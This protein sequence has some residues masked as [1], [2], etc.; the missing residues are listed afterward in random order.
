MDNYKYLVI[1]EYSESTIFEHYFDNE[2]DAIEDYL[3]FGTEKKKIFKLTE[4]KLEQK[5]IEKEG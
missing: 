3:R 5:L 2:S 1:E 4:M